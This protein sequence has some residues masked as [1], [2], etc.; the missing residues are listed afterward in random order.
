MAFRLNWDRGNR[1]T[2]GYGNDQPLDPK[3]LREYRIELRKSETGPAVAELFAE[4]EETRVITDL[5]LEA[6]G[7][8]P[9]AFVLWA[10]VEQAS[11]LIPGNPYWHATGIRRKPLLV[12]SA[13]AAIFAMHGSSTVEFR[14]P[15]EARATFEMAG[16]SQV[17]FKSP[18]TA[19]ATFTMA[20]SSTVVFAGEAGTA[21]PDEP[22]MTSLDRWYDP[23]DTGERT[24]T[25]N[26][27]EQLNDK[28][29]NGYHL[30][31][32][33][34]NQA[35]TL[36]SINGLGAPV[37]TGGGSGVANDNLRSLS[38]MAP[39]SGSDKPAT[40][41]MVVQPNT[42][43]FGYLACFGSNATIGTSSDFWGF[44]VNNSSGAVSLRKWDGTSA[45]NVT[46]ANGAL[47]TSPAIITF[48]Q[49]GTAATIRVNGVQVASGA[50][51]HGSVAVDRFALGCLQRS[52]NTDF[53]SP[54]RIGEVLLYS[55]ALGTD[56]LEAN[57]AYLADK[58]GISI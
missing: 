7:F 13:G 8:D 51:D 28:S 10:S 19:E 41:I 39:F 27:I 29:G 5:E 44:L 53:G 49:T 45:L 32:F 43:Q 6:A 11:T 17:S 16:S 31:P 46:S 57:E 25:A 48:V 30:T 9:T 55:A 15:Y 20:G 54:T 36:S 14:S 42:L 37:F 12:S 22:T 35:P 34:T 26:G 58:W 4:G 47:S 50:Q 56:D 2:K 40:L 33:I 52:N 1:Q 3:A 21:A 38:G 23:S 24:V 18:S